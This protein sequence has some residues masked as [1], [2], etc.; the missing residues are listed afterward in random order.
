[1]DLTRRDA[2]MLGLAL[3]VAGCTSNRPPG[4]EPVDPDVA[5]AEAAVA[6]E[7]S[8]LDAYGAA[9]LA[10]PELSSRLTPLRTEHEA[11]LAAATA[12]GGLFRPAS[13]VSGATST[14][15][16]PSP[17]LLPVRDTAAA[18]LAALRALETAVSHAHALSAITAS[19]TLAPVLASLA[20]P[21]GAAAA[22][23]ADT[24]LLPDA[25]GVDAILG[26]TPLPEVLPEPG[27][28]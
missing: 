4:P 27:D 24:A 8:L 17:A 15:L 28:E 1:M 21:P 7:Q 13:R 26:A 18:R 5:L 2:V 16:A 20:A 14:P 22:A 23:Q 19:L 6:R 25:E 10:H 11:H 9:H 3:A 12:A